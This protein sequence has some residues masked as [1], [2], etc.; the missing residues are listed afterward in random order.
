MATLIRP[1]TTRRT[2]AL[3]AKSLLNALLFFAVFMVAAPWLASRLLPARL[4]MPAAVGA[5]IGAVL[6]T[7]GAAL[8]LVCLDAF[9]R[10]GRGTP[11]PL[12]APAKLVE[13][14]PFAFVRN[15]IMVGELAVIWGIAFWLA[16]LGPLLYAAAISAAA[17]LAV[18]FVEEPELRRRFGADYDQY[19]RRVRRWLPGGRR[20]RRPSGA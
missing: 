15:P 12:D 13:S 20:S 6:F 14:G 10:R 16:E 4:P 19:C 17:H 1:S 18:V 7:T 3:Y 11:L 9:G 2:S 8:W 5:V